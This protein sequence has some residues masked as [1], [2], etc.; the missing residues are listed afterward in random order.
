MKGLIEVRYKKLANDIKLPEYQTPGD[1][2]MDVYSNESIHIKPQQTVCIGLGFSIEIPLGYYIQ[3]VPRSGVSL[4]TPL[5]I[6]NSPG[7]IDNGYRGELGIIVTNTSD[8]NILYSE[9]YK[10]DQKG[11][12]PGIYQINK[13]DRI[14]QIILMEF[15]F[16]AF[17]EAEVLKM[18]KR[19]NKGFGSTGIK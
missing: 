1:A 17:R 18:S 10:I 3:V 6:A 9:T 14:A 12:V 5:R 15:K 13:G 16:M 19:G 4:H 2:G 7:T 8:R 11:N